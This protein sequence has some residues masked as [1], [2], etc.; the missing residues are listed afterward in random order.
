MLLA[1]PI[2]GFL[3]TSPSDMQIHIGKDGHIHVV[4]KEDVRTGL[5][6]ANALHCW[7]DFSE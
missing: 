5:Q 4:H 2:V 6:L 7:R 1:T 3:R